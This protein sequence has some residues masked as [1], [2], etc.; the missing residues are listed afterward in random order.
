MKKHFKKNLIMIEE[1][2]ENCQSIQTCWICEKCIEN[3]N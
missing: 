3:N 1:K 2:E